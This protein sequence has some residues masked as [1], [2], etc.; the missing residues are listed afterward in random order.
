MTPLPSL[1]GRRFTAVSGGVD[2][3]ADTVFAFRE[4]RLTDVVTGTYSGG[5]VLAGSL[6]GTRDGSRVEFRYSHVTA[7]GSV[8]SGVSRDRLSVLPD[9]RLRLD[10]TWEWTSR[11]GSGTSVLEEVPG[12]VYVKTRVARPVASLAA[13]VEFYSGLLGLEV[14]GSFQDHGGYDGVFLALPGGGELE[15][16]AGSVVL[17]SAPDDLLC[18][19]F[20]TSRAA[21]E[22]AAS[23]P[24]S[25]ERVEAENPYWTD[26]GTTVR[27]PDGYRVVLTS[28]PGS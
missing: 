12:P 1:D 24:E 21:S 16:T 7:A 19:Y 5:S 9:G 13:S 20:A 25:V 26:F 17:P 28:P 2:V 23:L 22:L 4:D 18:L 3:G 8:E 11:S 27:D 6:V 15:L 14:T 10:E